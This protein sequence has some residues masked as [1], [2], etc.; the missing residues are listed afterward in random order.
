MQTVEVKSMFINGEWTQSQ[1]GGTLRVVNPAT[2]EEVGTVSYGDGKDARAAIEAA[3]QA[4]P[5]WSA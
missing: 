2:G 1:G 5:G 3:H 4:F